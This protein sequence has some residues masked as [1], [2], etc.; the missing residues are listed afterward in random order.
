MKLAL[1][2]AGHLRMFDEEVIN[3]IKS[4]MEGYDY[5]LFLVTHYTLERSEQKHYFGHN[6]KFT[7]NQIHD[8]FSDLP[9]KDLKVTNDMDTSDRRCLVCKKYIPMWVDPTLPITHDVGRCST[10]CDFCK[11]DTMDH[12]GS[13]SCC[14]KVWRNVSDGY[15][16][17]KKYEEKNDVKYDYYI[18]SRPDLLYKE[19]INFNKLPKLDDRLIIGFG[20]TLGYPND[21]FAIGSGDA[22]KDYSDIEPA[23]RESLFA[24]ERVARTLEKYPIWKFFDIARKCRT[25]DPNTETWTKKETIWHPKDQYITD[26]KM[27]YFS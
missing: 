24:H 8:M 10:H 15:E 21:Q 2:L 6:I 13:K 3:S 7:K 9:L 25:W 11:E 16:L 22:F 1:I 23:E 5:D 18:R 12:V 14:W 19:R 26:P 20:S 4:F 27:K 17:C